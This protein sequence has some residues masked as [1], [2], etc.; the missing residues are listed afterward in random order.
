MAPTSHLRGKNEP[1]QYR[2]LYRMN[3]EVLK[4]RPVQTCIPCPRAACVLGGET[5]QRETL[6]L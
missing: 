6:L 3:E 4:H 2:L 5:K 1:T